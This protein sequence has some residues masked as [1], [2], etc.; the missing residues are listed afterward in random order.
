M[1]NQFETIQLVRQFQANDEYFFQFLLAAKKDFQNIINDEY[2]F[3]YYR[4]NIRILLY[5]FYYNMHRMS[6]C[7]TESQELIKLNSEVVQLFD[8]I[9][10]DWFDSSLNLDFII[11]ELEMK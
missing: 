11:E 4:F 9:F 3:G 10:R 1:L 5:E 7:S 2:R 8:E 6:K